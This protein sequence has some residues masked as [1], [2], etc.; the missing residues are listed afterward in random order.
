MKVSF[1]N[2]GLT[3]S[4]VITSTIFESRIHQH[5]IDAAKLRVP[6]ITVTTQGFFRIRTTLTSTYLTARRVYDIALNEHKL[7]SL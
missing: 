7:C 3:A 5:V 6:E 4:V 1:E 2:Y